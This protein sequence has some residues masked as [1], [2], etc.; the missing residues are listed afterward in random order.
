M[1]SFLKGFIKYHKLSIIILLF[2]FIFSTVHCLKPSIFY[3]LNGGFRE[4]GVGYREKTVIPIWIFAICLAILCYI[5]IE[6][7]L[8]Y[9]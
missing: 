5:F 3:N 7:I 9:T 8:I 1:S 2:I 6:S 4:F